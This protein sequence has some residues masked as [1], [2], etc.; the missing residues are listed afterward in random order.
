MSNHR[1]GRRGIGNSGISQRARMLLTF[2]ALTAALP[3]NASA[4]TITVEEAIEGA[5][6]ASSAL[7]QTEL[8]IASSLLREAEVLASTRPSFSFV[9]DPAYGLVTQ[10][11]AGL[12]SPLFPAA[13]SPS[14][15]IINSTSAGVSLTQPLP[16]TGIVSGSLRGGF[17]VASDIPDEGD[18][19]N[20]FAFDPSLAIAISQ[21]IFVDGKFIDTEQ[22]VLTYEQARRST[23]E[24]TISG[25]L[26][27]RQTAAVVVALYTRLGTLRR[28]VTLQN[29]QHDLL[30]GRLEQVRIRRSSGQASPQ[31]ELTLQVQINRLDDVRLQSSLAIRELELELTK[32]TGLQFGPETELER[33]V[34]LDARAESSIASAMSVI[35]IEKRAKDEALR[36]AE[37]NLQLARKQPQATANA[38]LS[39]TPRYADEREREDELW[40]SV[41]DYFGEGAGIDVA[42]SIGIS[43]PLGK[44]ETR[45]RAIRQAEIAVD[46]AREE[47]QSA[48]EDAEYRQRLFDIRI[49]NLAERIELLHFELDFEESRL[50]TEMELVKLGVSTEAEVDEIRSDILSAEIELEDLRA[51]LFLA[52]MDLA[53]AR[54]LDL[55]GIVAAAE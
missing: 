2:M 47:V 22:P 25:D 12:D 28:A 26:V 46:L 31:E 27:R 37:V 9:S 49:N 7:R 34:D 39:I 48:A 4:R 43:V 50:D 13:G 41:A 14:T 30:V 45:E 6:A 16:T 21:P 24:V 17:S 54:G 23:R 35:T 3:F 20:T 11:I 8:R 15:L 19:S 5:L 51:Q 38:A 1:V 33:L 29:A 52:R 42:L 18:I 32:L 36:R 40:G 44:T 53:A 55:A 10:R